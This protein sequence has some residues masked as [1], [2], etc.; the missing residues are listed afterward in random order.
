MF[1]HLVEFSVEAISEASG[2]EKGAFKQAPG[3]WKVGIQRTVPV[4]GDER[5]DHCAGGEAS[6]LAVTSKEL[7]ISLRQPRKGL[8]SED[9]FLQDKMAFQGLKCSQW[10]FKT[11]KG[12]EQ[13]LHGLVDIQSGL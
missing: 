12:G 9:T 3:S 6:G 13:E 8:P 7:I 4:M 1:T 5:A 11:L 10:S 2:W